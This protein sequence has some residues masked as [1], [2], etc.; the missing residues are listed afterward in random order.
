MPFFAAVQLPFYNLF[1]WLYRLGIGIA[2][3]S[4]NKKATQWIEG[5]KG[6]LQKIESDFKDNTATTVWMH[7]ASLGEFE[8]GRT[9]LELI[10]KAHPEKKIVLTFF[11][12]S[13]YEVRKNYPHADFIY[14]LPLDGTKNA[15]R[16]LQAIK[17]EVAIFI[18]YEF[19]F[20]YL[21]AL[22]KRNIPTI[23]VSA[24]FRQNQP[25]FKWFG[26]LHREMLHLFSH[27]FVQDEN[28]INL[29]K[30]AGI[31]SVTRITD[32]RIDRVASISSLAQT[33]PSVE[34][35]LGGQKAFIGGSIYKEENE[36]VAT[37]FQKGLL[38]DKLILAPHDTGEENVKQLLAAWGD[39][40]VRYTQMNSSVKNRKVLFIDTIGILSSLYRYG[41]VAF[42]GGGF[43]KSIHNILEPAAF[44]LPIV[45]GPNHHK[46]REAGILIQNGGAF[47]VKNQEDFET[48]LKRLSEVHFREKA[49]TE[50]R[51][52]IQE[53][54]GG[55]MIVFEWLERAALMK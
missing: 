14:Y 40:A 4:G 1:L 50:S 25:F 13:G 31:T 20:H 2:A 27:L 55:S 53:N 32:T 44:G 43:G 46:F 9:L 21:K 48:V 17:P 7:C 38:G 24:I 37:A 3:L 39:E 36:M 26:A 11:S 33:L 15:N 41:S 12:P 35:F 28:S 23:L 30:S 18:K 29:L 42:I 22:K 16:F 54:L 6:L 47:E 10:R 5:R 51:K 45:S 49:G 19:W 34:E 8:Q 52:F